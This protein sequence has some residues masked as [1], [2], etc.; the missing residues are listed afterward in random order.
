MVKI[1]LKLAM[2]IQEDSQYQS[3]A[4]EKYETLY[5][6]SLDVLTPQAALSA[7][8]FLIESFHF[9]FYIASSSFPIS[10][11]NHISLTLLSYSKGALY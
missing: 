4:I 6:S 5:L 10:N 8:C 2:M 1:T 11:K 9:F 3:I 7:Y